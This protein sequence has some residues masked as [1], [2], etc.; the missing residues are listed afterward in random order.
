MHLSQL[1]ISVYKQPQHL[2]AEN[3]NNLAL[4]IITRVDR[5]L[6][7]PSAPH[8]ISLESHRTQLWAQLRS[9]GP[10]WHQS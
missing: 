5:I 1:Y 9:E 4:S 10:R 6:L 2:A 3:N 8:G 7:C